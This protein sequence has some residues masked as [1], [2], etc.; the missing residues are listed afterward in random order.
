VVYWIQ[1]KQKEIETMELTSQ[2]LPKETCEQIAAPLQETVVDY[3]SLASIVRQCHWAVV[4]R[5]FRSFHVFMDELAAELDTLIDETAERMLAVG[6]LPQGQVD[7][8]AQH[9]QVDPLPAELMQ[10][11]DLVVALSERMGAVVQ[12][13]RQRIETLGKL[14][15]VSEDML[16]GA[17]AGLEKTLWM[18]QAEN[19]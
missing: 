7:Y 15:P 6:V 18:L 19:K 1:Y 10:K 9:A 2:T 8:V 5:E 12:R 4:G 14:D 11:S 13:I 16:I 3:I 17:T